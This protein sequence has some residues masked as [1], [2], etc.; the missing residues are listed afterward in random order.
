MPAP[1]S[2]ED[3]RSVLRIPLLVSTRGARLCV[4]F[5]CGRA[6]LACVA[7]MAPFVEFGAVLKPIRP[8]LVEQVGCCAAV[9]VRGWGCAVKGGRSEGGCS[10]GWAHDP[11]GYAWGYSL[12]QCLGGA[13]SSLHLFCRI[14]IVGNL[15]LTLQ[16][17]R[18]IFEVCD[19]RG[20]S[21]NACARVG[22]KLVH[23]GE[24]APVVLPTCWVGRHCCCY[25]PHSPPPPPVSLRPWLDVRH[26]CPHLRPDGCR[27]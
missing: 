23:A 1:A 4:F 17:F 9:T 15:P 12:S 19:E 24:P 21:V 22:G 25:F 2:F 5:G 20:L 3:L 7:A 14:R 18:G 27:G 11:Q 13:I 6:M 26:G 8:L 10:E 16:K